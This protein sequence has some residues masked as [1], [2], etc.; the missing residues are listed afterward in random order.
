MKITQ[1]KA[2]GF[3]C[4][5]T[6]VDRNRGVLDALRPLLERATQQV[7]PAEEL[8]QC[9]RTLVSDKRCV[10]PTI[11]QLQ[12]HCQVHDQIARILGIA[13]DEGT[14]WEQGLAF[15]KRICQWPIYEDVPGALQYLSKF[16]RLVVLMP[17][18]AGNSDNLMERLP[19]AFDAKVMYQAEDR[20]QALTDTLQAVGLS[21]QE[22]LPVR[23]QEEDDPWRT[24]IDF[25][26]CTLRRNPLRPWNVTESRTDT[27][28]C[29]FASLAD[30]VSAHQDAL[31]L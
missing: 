23:S 13:V 8:L 4:Y 5:G 9:Y 30:L 24:L 27:S 21:R 16:Y 26:V 14:D 12:L 28:R 22:L 25:P 10:A 20:H 3:S 31:R 2:L 11:S 17:A 18:D 1:Y 15:A 29:E 19:V 7:P 6:L